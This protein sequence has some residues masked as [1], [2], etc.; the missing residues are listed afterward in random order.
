MFFQK[1][2][3]YSGRGIF[4]SLAAMMAV[5]LTATSATV[6]C[7]NQ[8]LQSRAQ[9]SEANQTLLQTSGLLEDLVAAENSQRGF[10]L[11]GDDSYLVA[12]DA[13]RQ[14][15][16]HQLSRLESKAAKYGY[17]LKLAQA[18]GLID[19]QLAELAATITV[20]RDQGSEPALSLV[21]MGQGL[22]Y[23]NGIRSS[24]GSITSQQTT[25]F[26]HQRGQI[27]RYSN[28]AAAVSEAMLVVVIILAGL[29]FYL[30]VRAIAAARELDRA[31][32][33]FV[34]LASHQL[35]TPA[36]GIKSVLATIMA[37]DFGPLTERQRYFLAKAAESN[38]RELS[39]IE[40]LLNVAKADAGRLVLRPSEV[41]LRDVID[42]IVNEQHRAIEAKKLKLTVKQPDQP[43]RLLADSEKLYMAIGNLVD[44]ARKY[45]PEE[46]HITVSVHGRRG[47]VAV[48]VSDT[49]LG[50]DEDEIGQVFDR[51]QRA[52]SVLAGNVEGTGLGLYLARRIVELHNGHIEVNSKKGRGTT[53]T[54]TLPLRRT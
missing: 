49:G 39:I 35:R 27:T 14:D 48:E 8:L 10:L 3:Q 50:I 40:E 4:F 32:D 46:G 41:D 12:Y 24:L 1:I 31:K 13:S 38:Q 6:Y 53:F 36:T 20:R 18:R 26:N 29:V 52:R 15:I 17:G 28:L 43:V 23:M 45:T 16:P 37:E 9:A 51:F 44:N 21:A 30:F 54:L 11:T 33:E 42:T 47:M 22:G 2:R 19:K 25:L 7:V 34:S 5:A